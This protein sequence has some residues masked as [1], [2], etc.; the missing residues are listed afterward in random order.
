MRF[1]KN[2]PVY[3]T[4]LGIAAVGII[5]LFVYSFCNHLSV[6]IDAQNN[7][8]R[9]SRS[10]EQSNGT[11]NNGNL[12]YFGENAIE[13]N[14]DNVQGDIASIYREI[15]MEKF[16]IVK[17]Q[18]K[19]FDSNT[20]TFL[21]TFL[22]ALL[23]TVFITLFIKNI[24]QYD[25]FGE[26]KADLHN[27]IVE[28][29]NEWNNKLKNLEYMLTVYSERNNVTQ[30]LNLVSVLGCLLASSKY[31]IKSEYTTLVYMI[32][33]RTQSILKDKFKELKNIRTEDKR[34]LIKM[35]DNCITYLNLEELR[36]KNS[37]GLVA[38][39]QLKGD[40]DEIKDLISEIE[41]K[42]G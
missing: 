18:H 3:F 5:I 36:E 13:N 28:T 27:S 41:L 30:I 7:L 35:I 11:Q 21:I 4:A 6:N 31:E 25:K 42:E 15:E 23:F 16:E 19:M 34:E 1:I 17:Q 10:Y 39:Q 24:E 12:N 22:C 26:I 14:S 37:H 8:E 38:F 33:R 32:R 9:I 29:E 20:V 2:H 40:L